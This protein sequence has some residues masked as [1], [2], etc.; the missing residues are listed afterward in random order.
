MQY[1]NNVQIFGKIVFDGRDTSG[2]IFNNKTIK[3]VNERF[4]ERCLD[5]AETDVRVGDVGALETRMA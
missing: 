2:H 4:F 5:L 3:T 1:N